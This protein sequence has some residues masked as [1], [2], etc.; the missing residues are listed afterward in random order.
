MC[1]GTSGNPV[2]LFLLWEMVLLYFGI[3]WRFKMSAVPEVWV[4]AHYWEPK[5]GHSL[6]MGVPMALWKPEVLSACNSGF[7]QYLG[8]L[9]GDCGP[10]RPY[11]T[12]EKP[13]RKCWSPWILAAPWSLQHCQDTPTALGSARSNTQCSPNVHAGT[14]AVH[15]DHFM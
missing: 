10:S 14:A 5:L 7:L 4:A 2:Y 13:P 6:L 8:G 3:L 1:L 15:Y 12:P 11:R 9:R